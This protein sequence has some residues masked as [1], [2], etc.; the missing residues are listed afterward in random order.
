[1][2]NQIE[3]T[4]EQIKNRTSKGHTIYINGLIEH[5]KTQNNLYI[6]KGKYQV[7]DLTVEGDSFGSFMCSCPDHVYRA[8]KCAHILAVQFYILKGVN[9]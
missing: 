4:N 7:E 2:I 3:L 6:V 9:A 8:V 1:M 5:S